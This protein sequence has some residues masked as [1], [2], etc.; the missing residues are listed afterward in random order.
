MRLTWTPSALLSCPAE[1]GPSRRSLDVSGTPMWALKAP[2]MDSPRAQPRDPRYGRHES[3]MRTRGLAPTLRD[4]ARPVVN[5]APV[6]HLREGPR[7]HLAQTNS[8]GRAHRRVS[9][10]APRHQ[11]PPVLRSCEAVR[12]PSR[13][14]GRADASECRWPAARRPLAQPALRHHV[15]GWMCLSQVGVLAR[16][17]LPRPACAGVPGGTGPMFQFAINLPV[18]VGLPGDHDGQRPPAPVPDRE[19]DP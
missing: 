11:R 6:A 9:V 4:P 17:A 12:T 16:T 10:P 2:Q 5:R 14:R 8:A 15:T 18:L 1:G 19:L 7:V 3:R 13:R